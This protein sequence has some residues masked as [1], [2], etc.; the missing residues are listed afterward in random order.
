MGCDDILHTSSA[1]ENTDVL[2]VDYINHHTKAIAL[3]L[4]TGRLPDG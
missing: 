1:M 4:N 2:Y 3:S